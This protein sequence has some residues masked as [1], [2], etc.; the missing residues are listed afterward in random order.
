M[1]LAKL[2]KMNNY[3][4]KIG[5]LTLISPEIKGVG[6]AFIR[7]HITT[8]DY[9]SSNIVSQLS[10]LLS[11][12]KK[13]ISED[14]IYEESESAKQIITQ[15]NEEN[16]KILTIFD[17]DYPNNLRQIK[18]AP[19]IIF[20]KGNINILNAQTICIIGTREPNEN[21]IKITQRVAD[22]YKQKK[23]NICNGL[24]DGIDTAAIQTN[25]NFYSNV[26]GIVAGGLNYNTKKTLLKKTSIN[27]EK[28]I[29]AGG[30]IISEFPP[31]KKEDTFSVVKSCRL[32]AGVSDGLFLIQSSIDG[33]SKFTIKS[34]CETSRPIAVINPLKDDE[35][36]PSYSANISIR[37]NKIIGLSKITDLKTEKINTKHI[38]VI[39]SKTDYDTFDNLVAQ[40]DGNIQ[41][42][43]TLFD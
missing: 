2:K 21:G 30:V 20:V 22:H 40:K 32:Q 3:N 42:T 37:E 8:K 16:I 12:N 26:I 9:F 25:D 39:N 28:V 41:T 43:K 15:C 6:P 14:I 18:D 19:S 33:G 7:K 29:E 34:F 36:N 13:P 17:I 5:L 38:S 4:L 27:A 11:E 24:A 10:L 1:W 31:D 23:W 35:N